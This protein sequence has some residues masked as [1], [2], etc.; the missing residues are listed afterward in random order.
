MNRLAV[1]QTMPEPKYPLLVNV[2]CWCLMSSCIQCTQCIPHL[3]LAVGQQCRSQSI[4]PAFDLEIPP[5]AFAP[6]FRDEKKRKQGTLYMSPL[7][8]VKR[9][10]RKCWERA[11]GQFLVKIWRKQEVWKLVLLLDGASCVSLGNNFKANW[12]NKKSFLCAIQLLFASF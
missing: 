11:K 8:S 6:D 10:Q 7:M 1:G 9:G 3:H 5:F 12:S 2:W 4:R